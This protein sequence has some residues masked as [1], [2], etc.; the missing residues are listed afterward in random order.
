VNYN[1]SVK[2][3]NVSI[4]TFPNNILANFTN[5]KEKPLFKAEAGAEKAPEVFSE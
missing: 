5:F 3:Y 2:D 4:K 1:E